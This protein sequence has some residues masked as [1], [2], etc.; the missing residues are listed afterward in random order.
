MWP[1]VSTESVTQSVT[2]SGMLDAVDP[3][4]RATTQGNELVGT[5]R[6]AHLPL[7]ASSGARAVW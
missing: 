1:I 2:E 4:E 3:G 6:V 5:G 7:P